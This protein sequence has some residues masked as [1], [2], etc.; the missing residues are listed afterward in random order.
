MD[1]ES[2]ARCGKFDVVTCQLASYIYRILQDS[3]VSA[4]IK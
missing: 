3:F 1:P 4:V 2:Q